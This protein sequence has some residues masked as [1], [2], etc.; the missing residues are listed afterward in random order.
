VIGNKAAMPRDVNEHIDVK[1]ADVA[2]TGT[3]E[4]AAV[5]FHGKKADA[6][7]WT[8]T[9][10]DGTKI[11]ILVPKAPEPGYH[12]HPVTQA[13]DAARYVPKASRALIKQ[14]LLNPVENPDD[15]YWAAEYK[16]SD[17]HSYMDSGASGIVTIYPNKAAKKLTSDNYLRGTMIHE[18]GHTFTDRKWGDDKKKGKWIEW[19]KAMDADKTSVS[20][21]ATKAIA[22]DA[23]ETLQ[24]YSSTKG[25]PKFDEYRAIVPHRFAM[26]DREQT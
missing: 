13:A 16:D 6:E 10:S 4:K 20:R 2:L 7:S 25:T 24:A 26:L 23:S 3:V 12:N 15:A 22:E 14:I 1:P 19:Q 11:E 5:E 9:Y 8:A 21:Y 17:F 18:T